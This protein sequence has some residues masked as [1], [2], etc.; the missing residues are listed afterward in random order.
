MTAASES[1]HIVQCPNDRR[2]NARELLN[3]Q[4]ISTDP[5]QMYNIRRELIDGGGNRIV[6]LIQ[7]PITAISMSRQVP[8]VAAFARASQCAAVPVASD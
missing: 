6:E 4:E 8:G 5:M 7:A 2:F 3:R 1:P